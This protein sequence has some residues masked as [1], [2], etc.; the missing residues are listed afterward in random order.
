MQKNG[1]EETIKRK[2]FERKIKKVKYLRKFPKRGLQK[3]VKT[4]KSQ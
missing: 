4:K 3:G 1:R 2:K